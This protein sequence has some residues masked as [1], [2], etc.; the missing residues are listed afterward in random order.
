MTP[1]AQASSRERYVFIDA[2]RG[3]ACLG[4][5]VYHLFFNTVMIEPIKLAF[6]AFILKLVSYGTYGVQ[7]FFV[8]SGFVIAHSLHHT[9]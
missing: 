8:L 6:P 7:I 4:V 1:T 3:F 2:L 9:L 5:L